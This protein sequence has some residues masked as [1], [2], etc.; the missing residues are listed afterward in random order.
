M[1]QLDWASS[2]NSGDNDYAIYEGTIG[3][4]FDNHASRQCGT[5]G[6][7]SESFS[8]PGGDLFYLVVPLNG[9]REGSYGLNGSGAERSAGAGACATQAVGVCQ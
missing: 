3:G 1:L 6:A 5:G 4:S 2:C 9:L 7:T 8:I